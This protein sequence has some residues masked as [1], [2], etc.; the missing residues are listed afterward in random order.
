MVYDFSTLTNNRMEAKIILKLPLFNHNP[1]LSSSP[2]S[3]KLPLSSLW[4]NMHMIH[5][6]G[7]LRI[8]MNL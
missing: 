1:G 3:K 6:Q 5:N 7:A 2:S 8:N 4:I